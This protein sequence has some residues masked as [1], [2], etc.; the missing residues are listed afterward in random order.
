MEQNK[1]GE[2]ALLAQHQKKTSHHL[3]NPL[4]LS[5][6]RITKY[7][8]ENSNMKE[9]DQ[10]TQKKSE[11]EEAKANQYTSNKEELSLMC[12]ENSKNA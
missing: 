4:L 9:K 11:P 2:T 6:N 12:L 10:D 1:W 8:G 7:V 3:P 5:M